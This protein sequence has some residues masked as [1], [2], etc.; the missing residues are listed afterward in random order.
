MLVH[1]N[2]HFYLGIRVEYKEQRICCSNF[3]DAFEGVYPL[4]FLENSYF[5][6]VNKTPKPNLSEL[7]QAGLGSFIGME[8][9]GIYSLF[10]PP[11]LIKKEGIFKLTLA[12]TLIYGSINSHLG[13]V[14]VLLFIPKK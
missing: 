5:V 14:F 6:I 12:L 8:V 9:D 4:E 1:S 11:P 10:L 7:R 2:S 3:S 13:V